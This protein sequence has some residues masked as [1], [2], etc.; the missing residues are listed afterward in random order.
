MK[1][2]VY[3]DR[4][5]NQGDFKLSIFSF[6]MKQAVLKLKMTL[7]DLFKARAL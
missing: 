6:V 1:K 5:N 4:G 7:W 3:E 2:N